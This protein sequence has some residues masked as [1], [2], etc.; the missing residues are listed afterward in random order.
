MAV[1][2]PS[3]AASPPSITEINTAPEKSQAQEQELAGLVHENKKLEANHNNLTSWRTSEAE[4]LL[5]EHAHLA[6]ENQQL[7]QDVD[8]G[9]APAAS[10]AVPAAHSPQH[11]LQSKIKRAG[12]KSR[13][14]ELLRQQR[15]AR[16]F[17]TALKSALDKEGVGSMVEK[18]KSLQG[19]GS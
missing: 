8:Q 18:I 19:S 1:L 5:E 11:N 15:T 7:K 14:S 3:V 4:P 2:Q 9:A 13:A 16:A 12:P 17:G 10:A 6:A